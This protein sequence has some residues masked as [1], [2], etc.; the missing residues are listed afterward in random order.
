MEWLGRNKGLLVSMLRLLFRRQ[1]LKH[2]SAL[3]DEVTMLRMKEQLK[4]SFWY[5]QNH[6]P[7][8]PT[9]SV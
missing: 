1:L 4:E 6:I 5:F 9:V 3:Q 7:H 2:F 8:I